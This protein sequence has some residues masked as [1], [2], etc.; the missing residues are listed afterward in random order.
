M[1]QNL[2]R[3]IALGLLGLVS[4][5][6]PAFAKRGTSNAEY[7]ESFRQHARTEKVQRMFESVLNKQAKLLGLQPN[8]VEGWKTLATAM[9]GVRAD[10]HKMGQMKGH[11]EEK[12]LVIVAHNRRTGEKRTLGFSNLGSPTMI[13]SSSAQF[14]KQK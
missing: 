10:M 8:H 2:I 12:G 1:R 14:A 3:A 7:R 6:A 13:P 5:S 4:A 11:L 9:G